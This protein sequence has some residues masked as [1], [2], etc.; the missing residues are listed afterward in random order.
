MQANEPIVTQDGWSHLKQDCGAIVWCGFL[1][2][3][4]ATMVFF[5]VFD[6][7]LLQDDDAPPAWLADRRTGYTVG[8]FFFWVTT[9]LAATLTAWL[10]DTRH[11]NLAQRP[12]GS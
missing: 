7:V 4:V 8:F 3:C 9:T 10:I 11:A 1:A 5:A 6:P 2:A 12:D